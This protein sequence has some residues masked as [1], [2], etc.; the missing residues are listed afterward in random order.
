MRA[1][2][3]I[4]LGEIEEI[5]NNAPEGLG[6]VAVLSYMVSVAALE[7]EAVQLESKDTE[8]QLEDPGI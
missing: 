4:T 5:K 7:I 2:N 1:I 3:G 6:S 8:L